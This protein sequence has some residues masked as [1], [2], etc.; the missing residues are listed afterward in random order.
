M[1]GEPEGGK[2]QQAQLGLCTAVAKM[3]DV[4]P[5]LVRVNAVLLGLLAAPVVI[6][7]YLIAGVLIGSPKV[8]SLAPARL[9]GSELA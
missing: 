3:V 5:F 2:E 7:T 6:V 9:R 1:A 8:S 4:D